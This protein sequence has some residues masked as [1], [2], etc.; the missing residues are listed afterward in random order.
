V[1]VT[2]GSGGSATLNGCSIGIMTT[3]DTYDSTPTRITWDSGNNGTTVS[4]NSSKVSDEITFNFT[5]TNRHG[6]HN[7]C[8]DEINFRW[9]NEG[10]GGLYWN[11]GGSDDT[12]TLNPTTSPI[13]ND[14]YYMTLVEVYTASG[15]WI[16]VFPE[17]LVATSSTP[18]P[19]VSTISNITVNTGILEATVVFN[20]PSVNQDDEEIIKKIIKD[21]VKT[22]IK[23][24]RK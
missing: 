18:E 11:S 21:I 20:T 16:T 7:Y 24:I 10:V 5:K 9:Q 1:T 23:V 13:A 8:A 2:A 22:I 17:A 6:I 15:E 12:M 19:T 14:C 3:D 4:A